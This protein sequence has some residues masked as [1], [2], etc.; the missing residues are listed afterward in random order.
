[1]GSTAD[2]MGLV[3]DRVV[4]AFK[5][6]SGHELHRSSVSNEIRDFAGLP[7]IERLSF[8]RVLESAGGNLVLEHD[9]EL[10]RRYGSFSVLVCEDRSTR[11]EQLKGMTP[12]AEGIYWH[13]ET[14]ERGPRAGETD[15]VA[16]KPYGEDLLLIWTSDTRKPE[17]SAQ[18]GR[19]DR[20]MRDLIT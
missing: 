1:M 3:V 10:A 17:T 9:P 8:A 18:W 16:E 13:A 11:D 15:W 12:D 5:A 4:T 14:P 19:L 7:R 20:V 6:A 2:E